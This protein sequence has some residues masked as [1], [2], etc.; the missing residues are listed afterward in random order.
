MGE[1]EVESSLRRAMA[2]SEP[3]NEVHL[4]NRL[5]AQDPSVTLLKASGLLLENPTKRLLLKYVEG[6]QTDEALQIDLT[7]HF[8]FVHKQR[9][10]VSFLRRLVE[11]DFERGQLMRDLRALEDRTEAGLRGW[12]KDAVTKV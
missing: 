6:A 4:L 12:F 9:E 7:V 3:S 11:S 1:T 8:K 2:Y 10:F 5:R